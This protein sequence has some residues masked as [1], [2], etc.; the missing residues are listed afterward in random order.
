MNEQDLKHVIALLLEDA[1]RLQQ[2]EPNAG[3]KA[4]I[5]SAENALKSGEYK[6]SVHVKVSFPSPS[7]GRN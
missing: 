7:A 5:W 6:G 4:R 2:I 3:T 1:K